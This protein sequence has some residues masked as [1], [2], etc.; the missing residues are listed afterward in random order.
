METRA[1]PKRR[2]RGRDRRRRADRAREELEKVIVELEEEMLAAA[3][4]LRF[5]E[6]GAD[7]RRAQGAAPRP[8]GPDRLSRLPTT[9]GGNANRAATVRPPLGSAS[10]SALGDLSAALLP[11]EAGGPSP[12]RVATRARTLI[13][14]MPGSSRA[15]LGAALV[16]LEAASLTRY[17]H[18]L[19]RIEPGRR[20]A[21][22][23]SLSASGAFGAGAVDALK[24]VVL[25]AAGAEEYAAE[26]HAT[27]TR[28]PPV[29]ADP[30]L[31]LVGAA[32]LGPAAC[33]AIVIG[34]GA[35]GAFAARELARAG[36]D[37]LVLEEGEHW[38]SARLRSA[39]PL[40]R[41]ASLYRDG[42]ATMALG[43][44]PIALPLGRAVGGTT[45]VNSG[46]LLPAAGRGDRALA[47]RARE[48]ARRGT[49]TRPA[50][51]R[52][53]ARSAS[54]RCRPR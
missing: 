16:G 26:I 14:A 34:S 5:E 7:P 20:S 52:S 30:P 17:G 8:R 45:V 43:T 2:R 48:R 47:R 23:R 49:A 37:V 19:G 12:E 40:Q 6:A 21:L 42:G 54:A 31:N 51:P 13:D 11:P 18:S 53:R 46:H 24:A 44:P 9:T 29:I 38:D 1:T 22:L 4:E 39:G 28:L 35:G 33:D 10:V 50:W 41:F 32:E 27:A 3:E 36:L 25:M 15:G